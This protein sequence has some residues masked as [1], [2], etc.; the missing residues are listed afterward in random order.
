M[1]KKKCDCKRLAK[2][3]DD[4]ASVIND[5]D[6]TA[7]PHAT[8]LSDEEVEAIR[9]GVIAALTALS[10]HLG[11]EG[12]EAAE[13]ARSLPPSRMADMIM[14]TGTKAHKAFV[15]DNEEDEPGDRDASG[16]R[17]AVEFRG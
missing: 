12:E 7:S 2:R 17:V 6:W 10:I 8:G 4:V 15:V 13:R 11:G 5:V 14:Y 1:S 9:V 3:L 16:V